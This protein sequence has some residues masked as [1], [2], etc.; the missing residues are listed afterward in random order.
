MNTLAGKIKSVKTD[1]HLSLVEISINDDVFKSILIE[2]PDSVSFL[3]VGEPINVLFK[4]T[5]VSIAKDL[6][7]LISLQNKMDCTITN[8]E[9]G[10]LL[11]KIILDYKGST[12]ISVITTG[13]VEQLE[14]KMGD[15]VRALIKTNEVIIAP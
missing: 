3:R 14:L 2:T 12:V 6:A 11:S 1:G 9:K 13:A 8:I 15:N 7:G 4:E 5:E 10:T